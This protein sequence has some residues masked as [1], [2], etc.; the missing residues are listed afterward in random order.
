MTGVEKVQVNESATLLE[1]MARNGLTENK[2][3]I[4]LNN[5][6]YYCVNYDP[7]RKSMYLK[8]NEGGACITRTLT[9]F[10]IGVFN[11]N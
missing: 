10:I 8:S 6:K 7:D 1:C 4:R 2:A 3:G 11:K 5:V 9:A